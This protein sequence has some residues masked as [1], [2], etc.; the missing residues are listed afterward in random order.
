MNLAERQHGVAQMFKH[1][2]ESDDIKK[3]I[4][5]M[6]LNQRSVMHCQSQALCL[7]GARLAGFYPVSFPSP[8]LETVKIRAAA[9]AYVE[10]L[11]RAVVGN[12]PPGCEKRQEPRR[13]T[14]NN[15]RIMTPRCWITVVVFQ[16]KT[17]PTAVQFFV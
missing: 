7:L 11:S 2:I 16:H 12:D 15:W 17:L 4:F 8:L 10:N 5:E 14:V 13:K 1:V 9:A 3:L 6:R